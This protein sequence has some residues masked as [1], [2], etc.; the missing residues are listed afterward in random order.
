MGGC[1][2]MRAPKLRCVADGMPKLVSCYVSNC[3]G[4]EEQRSS[5]T[6]GTDSCTNSNQG[7]APRGC[8]DE[9]DEDTLQRQWDTKLIW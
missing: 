5:C 1:F 4:A 9:A 3:E 2:E 6:H 8:G 7:E